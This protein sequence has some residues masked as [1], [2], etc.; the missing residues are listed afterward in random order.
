MRVG[1][2]PFLVARPLDLGLDQEQ[3]IELV[4]EVPAVLVRKLRAGKLDVALVSSI[5]LFRKPGYRYLDGLA[6]AGHA[7]V[8]SVQL[9]LRKPIE[10][11]ATVALDPASRTA[12]TLVQV[13]LAELGHKPRFLEVPADRD[14]REVEADGWLR[15]GDRAFRE[16]LEPDAHPVFNPSAAWREQTDLPFI[17]ATWIVRDGVNISNWLPAFAGA[18]ACGRDALPQLASDAAEDWSL[19]LAETE[20]YLLRECLYEPGSAMWPSLL[21]FRDRAAKLDLCE[22]DLIPEAVRFESTSSQ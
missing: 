6:V 11:L 2:V 16:Y 15:I 20:N 21:A 9:F 12:A 4:H 17:F 18:R 22:P 7:N 13:T 5:E 8:A 1:S 3:G 19:P 14:P 10:E